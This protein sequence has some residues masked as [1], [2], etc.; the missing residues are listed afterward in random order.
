MRTG[1]HKIARSYV[2][3]RAE[4]TRLREQNLEAEKPSHPEINVTFEDGHQAPLDT[5]RLRT[6]ITEAC[7]GLEDVSE[8]TIYDETLKNLYPGVKMKDVRTSL[9]MT[10]RTMVEKDPS[11]PWC[12]Q[13][14]LGMC[15]R[16]S[17]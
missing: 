5:K 12:V 1:E 3:Y 16:P 4:H 13:S 9:V 6:I 14:L 2:I 15:A 7:E 8:D 10:A 11:L 17:F